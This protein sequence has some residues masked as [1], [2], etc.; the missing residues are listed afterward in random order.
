MTGYR[1]RLTGALTAM[2]FI[3]G[4]FSFCPVPG[5]AAYNGGGIGN[6]GLGGIYIDIYS[7]YYDRDWSYGD[8]YGTYGCTWFATSRINELT[9]NKNAPLN[10]WGADSWYSWYGEYLGYT[11]DQTPKAYSAIC[12]N[13]H[14]AIIEK[15]ENG[16]AYI[17]EGGIWSPSYTV[18]TQNDYCRIV[19]CRVEN[20]PTFNSS[21]FLGYVHFDKFVKQPKNYTMG[22][23][24]HD[25][26]VNTKD[27]LVLKRCL[28]GWTGYNEKTFDLR[29]ADLDGNQT[30]NTR[31]LLIMKRC[32]SNWSGYRD[33][34]L[35]D[36]GIPQK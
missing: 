21:G 33:K 20:I 18:Y 34:Y 30:V 32:L 3:L 13:T 6:N 22:D 27:L 35:V 24:D 8:P 36:S 12:W 14:M 5:A 26:A 23:V 4:L 29:L 1:N 7:E 28:A 10:I 15:I 31:D 2:V 11:V 9:E 25:G 17:S 19:T 16:V